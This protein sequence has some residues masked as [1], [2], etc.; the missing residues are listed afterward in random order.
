MDKKHISPFTCGFGGVSLWEEEDRG[1]E[2]AE[3]GGGRSPPPRGGKT[4]APIL[5]TLNFLDDRGGGGERGGGR[6]KE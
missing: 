5:H 4:F 1:G 6:A 3:A 2:K